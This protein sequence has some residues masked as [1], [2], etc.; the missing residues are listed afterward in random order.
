MYWFIN[1]LAFEQKDQYTS[2]KDF[3]L[4]SDDLGSIRLNIRKSV[5]L[6][7]SK[8]LNWIFTSF[9]AP[10]LTANQKQYG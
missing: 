4:S 6:M 8:V 1:E 5:H 10:E 9:F 3:N 2:A 7:V